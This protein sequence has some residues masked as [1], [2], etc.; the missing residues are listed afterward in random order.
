M[1]RSDHSI[2]S[3]HPLRYLPHALS[4]LGLCGMSLAAQAAVIYLPPCFS[5]A[6]SATPPAGD[7]WIIQG[8]FV[9]IGLDGLVN[10]GTLT[11]N[12]C[13]EVHGKNYN[14][15]GQL[16]ATEVSVQSSCN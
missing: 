16:I 3:R 13:V 4:A 8:T 11:N 5:C 10:E 1:I 15:S 12:A 2:R 14:S 7:E 6:L 9:N